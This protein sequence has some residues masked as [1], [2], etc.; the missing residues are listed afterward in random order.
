[1]NEIKENNIEINAE[2]LKELLDYSS[3]EIF[4]FNRDEQVIYANKVCERNYGLSRDELIGK[5]RHELIE[6]N[7][8]SPSIYPEIYRQKKPVSII[9]T[10][11][12]G[13]ELLTS[14]IPVL[15]EDNEVELLI[16]TARELKDHK[17]VSL[18]TNME[19]HTFWEHGIVTNSEKMKKI[20]QFAKKVA[21]TNSTILIQGE[22]G[23][24][25]GV[26]A[27]YIHKM[28]ERKNKP[29]FTI[30]CVNIPEKLLESELFG[31]KKGAFTGSNPKGKV[32]LMELADGGTVFLDEIGDISLEL[33]AKLL[34]L[35]QNKEFIPVGGHETKKVDV[36]FIAAT[37]RDLEKLMEEGKFRE[38][39][40]YRLHVIDITLPPLRERKD[41]IIPLINY[42]LKKYNEEYETNKLI[43]QKC[44]DKLAQYKWPGNIRQLENFI[45]KLVIVSDNVIDINDLPNNF[46]NRVEN[47][48]T[49]NE[50]YSLDE[51]INYTKRQMVR[52]SYR[53]YKSSRKV[54]KDLNVSQTTATR[55]IREYCNDLMN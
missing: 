30:N 40:Y 14:A 35:L 17:I 20:L 7:Y 46:L 55:L 1:M 38:D 48:S 22:T 45:E 43:S 34:Q 47:D 23:T 15:N 42:Y 25:K 31:Y 19:A 33:Q 18:N 39:L 6:K 8:W 52:N 50:H 37:N 27:N 21:K 3:D 9:Q 10:T 28:S 4:I 16:T 41:D 44:L 13:V 53:K 51:A 26:L 12:T 49:N 2:T 29:F 11:I 5:Y 32:G 24:G 36:R 54:A